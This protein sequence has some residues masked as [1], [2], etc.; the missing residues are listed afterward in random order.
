[1]DMNAYV[2]VCIIF[3]QDYMLD[4]CVRLCVLVCVRVEAAH[5]LIA[6]K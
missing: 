2:C 4:E 6:V 1:M 5:M 3:I